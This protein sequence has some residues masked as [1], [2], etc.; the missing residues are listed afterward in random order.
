MEFI[1]PAF[2]KKTISFRR[3]TSKNVISY[4]V[5]A[6]YKD[7]NY[8]SGIRTELLDTIINPTVPNPVLKRIELEYTTNVTWDLPD[9]AYLDKDYRFR[10]YLNDVLLTSLH[11]KYNRLSKLITLNTDILED[12]N[13]NDKLELEYYQ[14]IITKDYTPD[15]NCEISI[16]PVFKDGYTYG[17]HNIII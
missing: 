1:L 9:D 10:M 13:V 6:H 16:K 4:E 3:L 7:N 12:Y 2:L 17:T 5:Y 8:S 15:G 14:D 11:Y